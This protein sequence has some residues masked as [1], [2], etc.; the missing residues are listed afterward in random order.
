MMNVTEGSEFASMEPL[1]WIN[2][3]NVTFTELTRP[4]SVD[5]ETIGN[6]STVST[7]VDT[8]P[9]KEIEIP[10]VE[11]ELE[12]LD[13]LGLYIKGLFVILAVFMVMFVVGRKVVAHVRMRFGRDL[14]VNFRLGLD[15][16]DTVSNRMQRAGGGGGKTIKREGEN[17][18]MRNFV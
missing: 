17:V 10:E 13:P 1:L 3:T 5:L 4:T 15:G 18:A 9:T 6:H 8:V 11:Y 14:S 7:F 16:V 2:S 12:W